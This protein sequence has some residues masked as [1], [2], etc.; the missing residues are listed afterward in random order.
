[1][2][3][4]KDKLNRMKWKNGSKYPKSV[5]IT[6]FGISTSIR[7]GE[8]ARGIGTA[9]WAPPEQWLGQFQKWLVT[10]NTELLLN[11]ED[12]DVFEF[13]WLCSPVKTFAF[14]DLIRRR[15]LTSKMSFIM[16]KVEVKFFGQN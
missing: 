8:Y 4:H 6:D 3:V 11:L 14:F 7:V 2:H 1:M 12:P 13:L 16:V 10:L 9:G 15:F 5:V